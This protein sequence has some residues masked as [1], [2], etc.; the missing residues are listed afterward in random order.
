MLINGSDEIM[1]NYD[2]KL[3]FNILKDLLKISE[4]AFI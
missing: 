1:E 4:T 3:A 2:G